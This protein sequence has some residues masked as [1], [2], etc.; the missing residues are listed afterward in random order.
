MRTEDFKLRCPQRSDWI[1]S[2]RKNIVN[3]LKQLLQT[4][5]LS[6]E[7]KEVAGIIREKMMEL[8][9][10]VYIDS[11]GNVIGV[12]GE[13]E[14]SILFDAHMDHVTPGNLNNWRYS[15]YSGKIVKEEIYGRGSVDMKGALASLIFGCANS[16]SSRKKVVACVV[17]EETNEGVATKKIIEEYD[18]NINVCV[19]GEPTN[20]KL[21]IGQ[22]GRAVFSITTR[23][24]TSHSS[25]PELGRNAIY[26]MNPIINKIKEI[27]LSLPTHPLM[28]SGSIAVTEITCEPGGGP[29]VPDKCTIY[30]DRRT[31]PGESLADVQQELEEIS[32]DA[33]ITLIKDQIKC[34]TGYEEEVEQY[35]PSWVLDREHPL[36]KICSDS[37]EKNF[38][39]K[40][41]IITWRFSTDGVATA[42][43]FQ[44]P[45]IGFG[46]GD[47]S[48]AHQP[49]E[50]I[51]LKDVF[52]AAHV[53]SVLSSNVIL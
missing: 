9:Y 36:V 16:N 42:G 34:Y 12:I 39:E 6:G 26:L 31:I 48:L 1:S 53:Y 5:S 7:E 21:S 47:P 38:G 28:G 27:N 20:L 2:E 45:T 22:R 32:R 43:D 11:M 17:H 44:I 8:G 14:P 41:D 37:I 10:E 23:G 33:E 4:P 19:L 46:P 24:L 51:R 50:K 3:L 13:E 30:V 52:I 49:N 35:F 40:P 18:G 15:P 29:I 25:M